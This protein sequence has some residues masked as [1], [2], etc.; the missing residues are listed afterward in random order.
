MST[1]VRIQRITWLADDVRL[2]ELRTLDGA[3][4][5]AWSA[6]AH[7][8]VELPNG[9]VRPY[10]LLPAARPPDDRPDTYRIGVKRAADSTGGTRWLFS[11]GQ[12]GVELGLSAPRNTF[13]LHGPG[14]AAAT[15]LIGGGIGVTPLIAMAAELDA[16]GERAWVL[17]YAV[18]RREQAAFAEELA[19]LGAGDRV[20]LHVDAEAGSVLDIGRILAEAA[21]AAALYA[22]GPNPLLDALATAATAAGLPPG[23]VRVERFSP[24][25]EPATGGGYTVVLIRSGRR[26]DIPP[27]AT[28]LGTLR[29]EGLSVLASCERG[30]C[31]TCETAVLGGT[32]D[33][34]DTLL[35]PEEHADGTSMMICCS[36]SLTPE[37]I[38]DL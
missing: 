30:T 33:H 29:K 17:H 4:L 22:C 31:G 19:A 3:A 16:R 11:R 25:A 15:V 35:S 9:V 5:P 8:D 7:V 32:P 28:I 18:A 20:R 2:F 21:P 23:A 14:E 37:L 6:G 24:T 12:V 34:R 27:G 38:L 1:A 36:G 13:G 10:S 26:L